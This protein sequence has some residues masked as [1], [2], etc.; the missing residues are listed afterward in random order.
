MARKC[1]APEKKRKSKKLQKKN[2][3]YEVNMVKPVAH[4][5]KEKAILEFNT[6]FTK[7]LML[8]WQ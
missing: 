8:S 3:T 4:K 5:L 7:N 1:D 6:S 2:Q